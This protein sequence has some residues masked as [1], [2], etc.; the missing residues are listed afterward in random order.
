M[1]EHTP[2]H[3]VPIKGSSDYSFGLVFS[4]FFLIVG[5][6][7]LLY[8]HNLRMWS[9]MVAAVFLIATLAAPSV[10]SPFNRLWTRFGFLL[11]CI[12]SPVA[13]GIVFFGVIAPMGLV[14]RLF[15]KD[16]L[17]LRLDKNASSYW[18]VR[19]PPGPTA[20]SLKNQF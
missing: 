15:S 16:L 2:H 18:I 10:L 8:G 5:L 14:M 6:L 4:I 12:V 3:I 13:L 17:R 7:P 9:L 11:H 19:T 1:H 20:E